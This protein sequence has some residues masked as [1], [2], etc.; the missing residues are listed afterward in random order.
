[1]AA[2]QNAVDV[3]KNNLPHEATIGNLNGLQTNV[4]GET[5]LHRARSFP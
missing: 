4:A 3:E 5:I 2:I 1:M